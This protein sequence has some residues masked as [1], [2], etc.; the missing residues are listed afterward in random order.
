[1]KN[2]VIGFGLSLLLSA[3]AA[4]TPNKTNTPQEATTQQNENIKAEAHPA[5]IAANKASVK[6]LDFSDR[7]DFERA[8]KGF[9]ATFDDGIAAYD[10]T[11]YDFVT[12][13]APDTVNPSL[14][15]QSK[16]L[17]KHG[18]FEV[19]DGI[20]QVRSFDLSNV[21]F[22]EG[23][24]G[25]IVVDPLI[26]KEAAIRA[27]ALVDRE[28]GKK[29]V[30]AVLITHS[31]IDHYGGIR[32]LFTE[33]EI[34]AG[35]FEII[36][37]DG[38]VLETVSENILAGNAMSRR[39]SYMF[40]GLLPRNPEGQVGVG[41]GQA[42][43][44]GEPGLL[45]PTREITEDFESF[46][47]D[48]VPIEFMLTLGAEAPSE[49]M[50]YM[51]EQRAFC[52]AEIINHTLHNLYTPRGA[53]VRDGKLWSAYIDRAIQK[54]ADKTDVSFGSHHW[55]VWGEE[56]VNELW[57]GQRDL[58]RYIHDQTVRLANEGYTM[59][60][61]PERLELPES[62]ASRFANRGYYGTLSHNSKAQYQL[63]FGYFDGNPANLNPL[64]PTKEAKKFVDYVG[65]AE[66]V[67]EKAEADYDAGEFRFAATA[68]NHLVFAEPENMEARNLL[69]KV[70][71][72][73]AYQAESGSWRNF[74]LTG[75][76]E[77]TQGVMD[78]PRPNT[79]SP[80][81]IKSIPMNLYFDL[82]A[83]KIDGTKAA[84]KDLELNFVITDTDQKAHLFLSGG[85]LHHRMGSTKDDIPTLNITREGLD[86][87]NL[88]LKTVADLRK[89]GSV[90]MSGNP[91]KIK[92]FFDLIEDPDYWF[93]IVR[94]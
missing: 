17:A 33:E 85:A 62:L 87:L 79:A 16:L 83:V 11:S 38:F 88:K 58:Y 69:A 49:Y 84:K 72:Q 61:I 42:I 15:R 10:P 23:D 13:E 60:E 52:Q 7:R 56:D 68:L 50:F 32:G 22:I 26:S 18:L 41:L 20:Y 74:Y 39:A 94:P 64:P 35:N 51:P 36:T 73:L 29:A 86:A 55:P 82:L 19:S 48:G 9:I 47:V 63:Y 40:G 65:G 77:L 3:C 80:D 12:G 81:M 34:E 57:R 14:W 89:D 76:Q 44:S 78:L 2:L 45:Y 43:S 66:A 6:A 5:T 31:H 28:L 93:E 21:T 70:Y 8:E 1:M 92:A 75:A 71:R 30:S 90:T 37:P 4:E 59:H 46:E 24:T 54:Y 53:K 25:W 91:L 27:K 67:L